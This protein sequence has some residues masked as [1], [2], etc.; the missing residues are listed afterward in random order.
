MLQ[1]LDNDLVGR[2]TSV[3]TL[4]DTHELGDL[5]SSDGNGR[6]RHESADG[7]QGDTLD[8]PSKSGKTNEHNNGTNNDRKGRSDD[9]TFNVRD[10]LLGVKHNV[11]DDL[12]HDSDRLDLAN[13]GQLKNAGKSGGVKAAC[14][15]P[16]VISLEVAKNQ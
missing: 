16:M 13:V 7:W 3:D 1:G 5:T 8:D 11:S 2:S 9:V 12:R 6:A 15:T 10:R 4:L 14:L